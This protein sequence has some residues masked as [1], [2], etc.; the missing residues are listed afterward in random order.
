MVTTRQFWFLNRDGGSLLKVVLPIVGG[1]IMLGASVSPWLVDPLLGSSLAWKLPID[2]GWQ[3]RTGIVSYGL[4]CLIAALYSFTI[5]AATVKTFKWSSF[6][7]GKYRV[8]AILCLAPVALFLLQYLF[9]DIAGMNILTQHK[10]QMLLIQYHFGYSGQADRIVIDPYKFTDATIL[11]RLQL[12][13]DQVSFGILLPFLAALF[14]FESRRFVV[15]QPYAGPKDTNRKYAWIVGIVFFALLLGRGPIA[16][17]CNFEVKQALASGNYS[18]ALTWLN[19]AQTLNPSLQQ[20]AASHIE[21]G[22]ALYFLNP[23]QHSDDTRIYLAS[24]YRSNKNYLAA[25]QELLAVWQTHPSAP[26]VVGEMSITLQSLAELTKSLNGSVIFRQ[27]H[28][29]TALIWV[30]L[31]DKVDAKNLYGQY[32]TGRIL[33]DVHDY[34]ACITQMDIILAAKPNADVRSSAITYIGLSDIRQGKYSEGRNL[35]FEALKSDPSYRNNTAR[36]ALSGLY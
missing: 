36:E 6:F 33:Y 21:R 12:L 22:E 5:A 23:N 25:Y 18:S 29:N 8:A 35:L 26:W 19:V 31:L 2:I 32:M 1:L 9:V 3:V 17:F 20:V 14:L 10:L 11:G 7:I 34:S 30:Q 4:L 24:V 15:T 28:D 16:T 27:E 13:T